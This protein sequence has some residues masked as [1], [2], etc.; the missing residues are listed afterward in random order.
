MHKKIKE[1]LKYEAL[2]HPRRQFCL[3]SWTS[4]SRQR[5]WRS[6]LSSPGKRKEFEERE[7]EL[8]KYLVRS[9]QLNV[10]IHPGTRSIGRMTRISPNREEATV[11]MSPANV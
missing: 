11:Q 5:F 1:K 10:S 3:R 7:R 6:R 8:Y 4:S 9:E 2:G